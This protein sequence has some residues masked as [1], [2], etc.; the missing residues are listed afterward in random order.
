[1]RMSKARFIDWGT[2]IVVDPLDVIPVMARQNSKPGK[3]MRRKADSRRP[4]WRSTPDS[5][6]SQLESQ[7]SRGQ[8]DRDMGQVKT[9]T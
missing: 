1:M 4:S 2:N 9:T 3:A 6:E 8:Q 7:Q 5:P